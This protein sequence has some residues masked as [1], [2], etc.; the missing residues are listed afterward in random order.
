[1]T[2]TIKAFNNQIQNFTNVLS[3][4]FPDLADLKIASNGLSTLCK[5]NIK[6]PIELFTQYV[7]KYRQIIMDRNED[8]LLNMDLTNGLDKDEVDYASNIIK[9]MRDNW[10]QITDEEKDN[11]WKYLQVLMKL[12]DKHLSEI[13]SN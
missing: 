2:S 6:K 3:E 11:I 5:F 1:M 13:L 9:I 12:I 4:R 8:G 7:Y 10:L